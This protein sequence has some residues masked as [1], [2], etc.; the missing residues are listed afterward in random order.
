MAEW[1]IQHRLFFSG[2][3]LH[4][5]EQDT[6]AMC[7]SEALDPRLL[8]PL[9]DTRSFVQSLGDRGHT[10]NV[11]HDSLVVAAARVVL[12][13]SGFPAAIVPV[14]LDRWTV[15]QLWTHIKSHICTGSRSS[16]D[17]LLQICI[18]DQNV[19]H[20]SVAVFE[21]RGEQ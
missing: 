13:G 21:T 15:R 10:G 12:S 4:V 3:N 19:L 2:K 14:T 11:Q 8:V 20:N 1:D 16:C 17:Q 5:L 9:Q 18:Y 6:L 7:M